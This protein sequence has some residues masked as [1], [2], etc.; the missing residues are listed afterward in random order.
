M[1]CGKHLAGQ[2]DIVY[3]TYGVMC[4]LPDLREWARI[5]AHYL[6]DGGFLY[7]ADTHSRDQVH[8]AG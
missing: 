5:I 7:V 2:F 1:T 4:W 3:A 8:P 6:E